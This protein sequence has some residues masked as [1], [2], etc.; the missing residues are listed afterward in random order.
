MKKES[1]EQVFKE[2]EGHFDNRVPPE[3]HKERFAAKLAARNKDV[4]PLAP[5]NRR[6]MRTLAIAASFALLC[7]LG[8][9]MFL[10]SPSVEQQVAAISPEISQTQF[11]FAN[12][13]EEQVRELESEDSPET[14]QLIDDT[15]A[16][17]AKLE[18]NYRKLEQDL[19]NGGNSKLILSAMITN[20]Q[21][22][23][24]LL[25]EVM[26]KVENIKTLNKQDNE[27]YTI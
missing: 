26:N 19:L 23:I 11:Y 21:T 6:W 1:I 8:L 2:L 15:L 22:R 27:N 14:K 16:Q 3:G 18:H 17:L 9:R 10:P 12:L 25:T 24:D 7:M 5:R 4:I 20:F 13:I